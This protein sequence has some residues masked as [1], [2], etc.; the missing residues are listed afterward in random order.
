MGVQPFEVAIIGNLG[1]LSFIALPFF[2]SKIALEVPTYTSKLCLLRNARHI[3]CAAVNT[4]PSPMARPGI[5]LA[6]SVERRGYLRI[7]MQSGMASEIRI[8]G[9]FFCRLVGFEP[10]AAS[11]N[12]RH[13]VAFR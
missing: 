3:C 4:G 9:R 10:A 5:A 2:L 11:Y 8:A 12:Q 6:R 7:E 13:R 1:L